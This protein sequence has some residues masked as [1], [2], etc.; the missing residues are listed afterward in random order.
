MASDIRR[1]EGRRRVPLFRGFGSR[2]R[3]RHVVVHMV[4]VVVHVVMHGR[5]C[6]HGRGARWR[7]GRRLLS[8]CVA[9][10]T[11]RESG[12]GNKTLDH[13]HIPPEKD[14]NG[15]RLEIWRKLPELKVNRI[16]PDIT[17]P[18]NAT[19]ASMCGW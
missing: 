7:S 4:M 12:G 2:R 6:G 13:G 19:S 15:Q 17:A 14:P 10:K 11:N 8:D 16:S 18:E 1:R 5:L 3:G 9:G